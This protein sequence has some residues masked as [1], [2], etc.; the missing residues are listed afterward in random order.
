MSVGNYFDHTGQYHHNNHWKSS[1]YLIPVVD[2]IAVTN[3][4]KLRKI[5]CSF[6]FSPNITDGEGKDE[7]NKNID[8]KPHCV[9][10]NHIIH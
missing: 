6:L 8:I 5:I 2:N 9:E 3:P 7:K 4:K 10:N 1:D